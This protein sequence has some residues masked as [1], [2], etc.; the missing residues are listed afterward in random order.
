MSTPA[1]DLDGEHLNLTVPEAA[2]ALRVSRDVVY[3]LCRH[4]RIPHVR[5]G[6]KVLIPRASLADALTTLAANR[7]DL[8][9]PTT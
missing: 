9:P 3:G 1:R 7:E 6:R 5:V 8:N 4:G 2:A